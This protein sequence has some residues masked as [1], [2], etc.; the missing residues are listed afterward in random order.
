MASFS[1]LLQ[2]RERYVNGKTVVD[3]I[4]PR[5]V[6]TYLRGSSPETVNLVFEGLNAGVSISSQEFARLIESKKVKHA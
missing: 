1:V 2:F 6:F 4:I 5:R 3:L